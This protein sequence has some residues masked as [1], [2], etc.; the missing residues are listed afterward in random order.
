MKA[1]EINLIT[2]KAL[3]GDLKSLNEL[4]SFLEKYNAPIAR[5]AMYAIL[6]QVVMNNY[7]DLG[8][9]CEECGGKCCKSGLPIPVYEFDYKELKVR[10]KQEELKNFRK[11]N[12]IYTLSRPCPFQKGWLCTI[13]TFKPY[14]CMSYPFATE[15]EQKDVIDSYKSGIPNFKVPDF[16]IAGKKVKEFMD[17]IVND[18]KNKVGREPSP[19]EL[20]EE[21]LKRVKR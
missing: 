17:G 15:D 12:G 5:Y 8:K 2:K 19:R 16:C 14:A 20:L 1:E 3:Q 21:V 10:L 9:Y 18:F 7:L 4:F 13:H 11:V 6:Y